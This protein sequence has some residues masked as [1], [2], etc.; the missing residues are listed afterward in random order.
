MIY[1]IPIAHGLN[2]LYL[3]YTQAITGNAMVKAHVI[4]EFPHHLQSDKIFFPLI[5]H[6]RIISAFEKLI[7]M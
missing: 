6:E 1:M 2:S 4:R 3:Q 7:I 5:R